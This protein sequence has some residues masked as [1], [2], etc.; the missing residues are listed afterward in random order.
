MA[1]ISTPRVWNAFVVPSALCIFY[2][3]V[4]CLSYPHLASAFPTHFSSTGMPSHWAETGS[5]L[6]ASLALIAVIFL[7]LGISLIRYAENRTAWWMI[8]IIFAGT[9]GAIVGASVEFMHAVHG[10]RE[11]HSFWW[12]A[13]GVI[14]ALVEALFLLI[15]RQPSDHRPNATPLT[16]PS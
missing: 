9:I 8:G 1:A 14:A 5:V 15:P 16:P 3:V 13:W 6:F 11:F 2:C 12:I 4:L 10:F 7:V